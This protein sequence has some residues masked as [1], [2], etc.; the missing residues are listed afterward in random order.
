MYHVKRYRKLARESSHR[1]AMLRNLATSFF[2]HGHINTTL[3]RCKELQP[4]V[5]KLIT[6]LYKYKSH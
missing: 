2:A 4:I 1:R 5:E 3:C 6:N